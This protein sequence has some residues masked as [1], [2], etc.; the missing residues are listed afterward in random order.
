MESNY[1]VLQA[2]LDP[3][4][5]HNLWPKG[6]SYAIPGSWSQKPFNGKIILPES[7]KAR[8]MSNSIGCVE[9]SCGAGGTKLVSGTP[10]TYDSGKGPSVAVAGPWD[11][12]AN[13]FS[14]SGCMAVL[15]DGSVRNVTLAQAADFL[16][17]SDPSNPERPSND[18]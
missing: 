15:M 18:W 12:R 3:N 4:L 1:K 13:A 17:C 6:L 16:R 8:G 9:A 14:S 5:D 2:P 10:V 7:F 11:G